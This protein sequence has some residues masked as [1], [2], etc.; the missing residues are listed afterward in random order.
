MVVCWFLCCRTDEVSLLDAACVA[1]VC[2]DSI[3]ESREREAKSV[4]SSGHLG[5][6]S[7]SVSF[8]A[9]IG[10]AI[11]WLFRGNAIVKGLS[12]KGGNTSSPC[13][14]KRRRI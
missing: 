3:A 7:E 12:F 14:N 8:P 10:S 9:V 5:I 1:D 11:D 13:K 2:K 4:E 6:I